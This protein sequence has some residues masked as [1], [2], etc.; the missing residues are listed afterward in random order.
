MSELKLPSVTI[1]G[2][3]DYLE[4]HLEQRDNIFKYA[5]RLANEQKA[6]IVGP[7]IGNF[8]FTLTKMVNAKKV[9]ELGSSIGYSTLWF[10]KAIG[11]DGKVTYT[12]FSHKNMEIAKSMA[13]KADLTERINFYVGDALEFLS[14]TNEQYDI[15]FLDLNKDMYFKA[16]EE[17][18]NKLKKGGLLIADNILWGGRVRWSL[19]DENTKTIKKFNT[20]ISSAPNLQTSLIPIRDGVSISIK[21]RD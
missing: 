12:D 2:I 8:L 7:I 3:E 4:Q 20:F 16:L 13:D 1:S 14:R 9:L 5:E 17:S 11:K 10:A 15:I 6:S 18:L 19:D 21:L